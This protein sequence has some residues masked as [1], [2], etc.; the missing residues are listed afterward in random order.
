MPFSEAL[1]GATP[2]SGP[3]GQSPVADAGIVVEYLK[4]K[5]VH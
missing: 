5:E 3:Q 1:C 2:G 4:M